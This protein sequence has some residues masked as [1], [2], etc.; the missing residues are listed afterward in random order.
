MEQIVAEQPLSLSEN[1]K[2][3]YIL[4]K[5]TFDIILSLLGLI[6]ISPFLLI[7]MASIVLEDGGSPFFFQPRIGKGC[8]TFQMVKFRSMY[9]NAEEMLAQLSD[10]EKKEFHENFKLRNDPRITKVGRFIRKTS[11]DE[12]PQLWNVLV[13]DMSLVGPRPPLLVEDEAY[14]TH[15]QKVMSVRPGITGYWQV[16][17]RSDTSF[18]ER[19]EMNEYYID[20]RSLWLDTRILFETIAVVFGRKG[21][22]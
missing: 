3:A 17:G 1:R 4:L 10:E 15:L 16:H 21:A 5:R 20:H 6:L 19:I 9:Q 7:V 2:T 13:G 8:Q 18:S 12:L 22:I 11:I 14:G